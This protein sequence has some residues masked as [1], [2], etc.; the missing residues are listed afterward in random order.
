[1]QEGLNPLL[2]IFPVSGKVEEKEVNVG[3]WT[4]FLPA[5][6]SNGLERK[7]R[8]GFSI[9]PQNE[10]SIPKAPENSIHQGRATPAQFPTGH[11]FLVLLLQPLLAFA[12]KPL[13]VLKTFY[14]L[15]QCLHMQFK[16][17]LGHKA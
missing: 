8:R 4:E 9:F 17:G 16:N 7:T 5:I 15:F 2:Q 3:E 10:G 11:P 6:P 1:M 13:Y 12:E 14:S